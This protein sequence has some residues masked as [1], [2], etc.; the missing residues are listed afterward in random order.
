MTIIS[1]GIRKN[2]GNGS[3]GHELGDAHYVM[4]K[5]PDI[6]IF[7]IGSELNFNIGDQLKTNK[8]FNNNYIKVKTRE[9]DQEYQLFFNKYGKNAGI[10]NNGHQLIIPGY[11]FQTSSD[12]LSIFSDSKLIKTMNKGNMYSLTI[13]NV[14]S[15]N[16]KTANQE[17]KNA[18]FN[19]DI[20][21]K[22]RQLIIK[23]IPNNNM[24]LESLVLERNI[25]IF[26]V[27]LH[28]IIPKVLR[29]SQNRY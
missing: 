21:G 9:K 12:N 6:I 10:K 3:L 11:L 26:F 2:F 23:I 14:P 7:H 5:N 4:N 16:W 8:V 19:V 18:G 15:G 25:K 1:Q 13:D 27:L 20:Y 28:T 17:D 22:N 24:F 29:N